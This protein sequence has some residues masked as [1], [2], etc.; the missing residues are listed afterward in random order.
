[1][2]SVSDIGTDLGLGTKSNLLTQSAELPNEQVTDFSKLLD[3]Q[4][5]QDQTKVLDGLLSPVVQD[6]SV[7]VSDH[8][9]LGSRNLPASL[10]HDPTKSS[11]L[12]SITGVSDDTIVAQIGTTEQAAYG[13]HLG[14][15]LASELDQTEQVSLAKKPNQ[16]HS[17]AR[18]FAKLPVTAHRAVSAE[19]ER[20]FDTLSTTSRTKSATQHDPGRALALQQGIGS[21]VSAQTELLVGSPEML[22]PATLDS[23]GNVV[24][25]LTES[26][27]K[28]GKNTPMNNIGGLATVPASLPSSAPTPSASQSNTPLPLQLIASTSQLPSVLTDVISTTDKGNDKVVVQLDPPELGRILIDFKFD[29]TGLQNVVV[30]AETPEALK[31]IRHMHFELLQALEQNGLSQSDLSFQQQ[32]FG[33]QAR[34]EDAPGQIQSESATGDGQ[35]MLPPKPNSIVDRARIIKGAIALDI[36][37]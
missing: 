4:D 5:G 15:G 6:T 7:K 12:I 37:V 23:I 25:E 35:D 1:M 17:N 32:S 8:V 27:N 28:P 31:Q 33:E 29:A 2:P 21:K 20:K 26:E 11:E 18:V 24:L 19:G 34:S 9:Q 10:E 13:T 14:Q 22:D 30:T 16:Q 3:D 36:K